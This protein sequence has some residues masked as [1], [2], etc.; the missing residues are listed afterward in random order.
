MMDF[1]RLFAYLAENPI[2]PILE[3]FRVCY[4]PENPRRALYVLY[5]KLLAYLID[6]DDE[7]YVKHLEEIFLSIT[8]SFQSRYTDFS[9]FEYLIEIIQ[10]NGPETLII[11]TAINLA[12]VIYLVPDPT[13]SSQRSTS[14]SINS[15]EN[16][17]R[18][19]AE[20]TGFNRTASTLMLALEDELYGNIMTGFENFWEVFFIDKAWSDQTLRIWECYEMYEIEGVNNLA[21][22]QASKSLKKG[23]SKKIPKKVC[24]NKNLIPDITEDEMW[25][26]LYFFRDN[27][28]NQLTDQPSEPSD[29]ISTLIKETKGTQ[30]RSKYCRTKFPREMQGSTNQRQVDFLIESIEVPSAEEHQW[31]DVR[32]LGEFT[33]LSYSS[34][35]KEKFLQL[36]RLVLEVFSTQPLRHFVHGF[37]LFKED[38]Q[39]WVFNRS[40]AYSSGPLSLTADKENFVRAIS[41]Y[42][43]MSDQELG[44]DSSIQQANGRSFITVS[45][46]DLKESR[47]FEVNP[48]PIFKLGTLVTCGTTCYETLNKSAVVKYSWVRTPGESE[49]DFLREARGTEG[50]VQY[51]LSDVICKISD[52][53][54]DLNFSKAKSWNMRGLDHFISRGKDVMTIPTPIL[55]DR[56]LTRI[57]LTPRGRSLRSCKTIFEFLVGIRDA[58]LGHRRLYLEK[59]LLHGDVSDGNIILVSTG[60]RTQGVLIDLDHAVKTEK[61]Q[62]KDENL[63]LTGTLKF[64]A[65]ERLLSAATSGRTIKR[66]YFH[67]LESFFYIFLVGCVEYEYCDGSKRLDSM[68]YWATKSKT[69]NFST[70]YTLVS[71][72][73]DTSSHGFTPSF[74]DLKDLAINLRTILFGE[75]GINFQT[76]DDHE[77]IYR[78]MIMA[79]NQT[80]EQI[81]NGTIPDRKIKRG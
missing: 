77:P 11:A 50:V 46:K 65:L 57:V 56:E 14:P 58:I 31:K 81:K 23:K 2:R 4:R 47:E 1:K 64:M 13:K 27:F 79:F 67:D 26:W 28:L 45:D 69:I 75:E 62:G 73:D 3:K 60:G 19:I 72:L 15:N 76:P 40:G 18:S 21:G 22:A 71:I 33:K 55:R 7:D 32:V 59:K 41:S 78:N 39:L 42:L 49:K 38:F 12:E 8:A 44:I 36:S 43:L 61:A 70:K 35:R 6:I 24:D 74:L 68:R 17:T 63:T 53:L 25:D 20:V 10:N 80:I 9:A 48:A 34:A 29:R 37:C 16:F 54:R 5:T 30:L 52:H 66:T 51:I